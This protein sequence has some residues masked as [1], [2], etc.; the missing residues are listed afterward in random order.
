MRT[1]SIS[2]WVPLNFESSQTIQELSQD[3]NLYK[4]FM[5]K[6]LKFSQDENLLKISRIYPKMKTSLSSLG[7]VSRCNISKL[8][9]SDL[10][11]RTSKELSMNHLKVKKNSSTSPVLIQMGEPPQNLQDWHQDENLLNLQGLYLIRVLVWH[12]LDKSN[13]PVQSLGQSNY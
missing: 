11:M 1:S 6:N 2:A 8:S 7:V 13:P 9:M 10:M 3:K 5:I 12:G 4:I